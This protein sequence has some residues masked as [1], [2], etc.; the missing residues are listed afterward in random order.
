MARKVVDVTIDA[1]GRDH[2]KLFRITEMSA[3]QAE[4]WAFRAVLAL[5]AAGVELP[6]GIAES[7]MAGLRHIALGLF[8]KIPFAEAEP[9]LD[10]LF[11]CIT[12]LPNPKNPTV[13]RPLVP[14]D[15]EEVITRLRLRMEVVNLHLGFLQAA[16]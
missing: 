5:G 7:G 2:G 10:E 12:I 13:V 3:T 4:K 1:E 11:S 14:D 16:D 6:D 15:T 8:L 9:L